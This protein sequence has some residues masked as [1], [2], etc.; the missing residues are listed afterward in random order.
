MIDRPEP[1]VPRTLR[2]DGARAAVGRR[3]SAA[4][5]GRGRGRGAS[6]HGSSPRT[7]KAVAIG[8]LHAYAH[9]AHE[10]R[11]REL[12]R[13]A[14]PRTSTICISS[15]VAPEIREYERFSTTVANAY[16]QPLMASYLDRLRDRAEGRWSSTAPLFLMMSGGGLTTL[17]TAARF[18]IRLVESGPAGGAILAARSPAECAL[19][20]GALLRHGR[21]HRQDLPDR[22]RRAASARA[23]SRSRAPIA[24]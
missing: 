22:R 19:D 1:L 13:G 17:E 4:A 24:S 16:V 12:L 7:S 20:G 14:C 5:A 8:F 3:R 23:S 10:R 15:E 9:D 18:P 21:H 2:F 6:L 11:A